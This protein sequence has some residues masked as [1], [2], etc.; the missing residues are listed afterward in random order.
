MRKKV[1]LIIKFDDE[2]CSN[3]ER[4]HLWGQLMLNLCELAQEQGVK[5]EREEKENFV[6]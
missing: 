3:K 6:A 1:G 5:Y 4:N 2:E